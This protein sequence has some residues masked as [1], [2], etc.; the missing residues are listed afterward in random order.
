MARRGGTL[1]TASSLQI[2]KCA[3]VPGRHASIIFLSFELTRKAAALDHR[4]ASNGLGS[5]RPVGSHQRDA[6]VTL[7]LGREI[8]QTL[9]RGLLVGF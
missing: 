2:E 8:L 9:D 7:R 4:V 3:R 5:R 6:G 1:A